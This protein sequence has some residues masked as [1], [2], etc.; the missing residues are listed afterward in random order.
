MDNKDNKKITPM[1]E[2]YLEI[3]AKYKGYVLFYRLGDFYEMFFDDALNISKALD[4]T[5]T[6]RAGTP[7]CGVPY[8]SSETYIK[9]LIDKGYKV[10]ICEQL[11]TAV[12]AKGLVE[13]EVKRIVTAGTVI[14]DSMLDDGSNNFIA[15]FFA[16]SENK[17]SGCGF[18]FADLSTGEIHLFEKRGNGMLSDVIS[19]LARYRPVEILFNQEFMSYRQVSEFVKNKLSGCTGGLLDDSAFES[20]NFEAVCEQYGL[21]NHEKLVAVDMKLAIKSLLALLRYFT[22]TQKN[23]VS[24][25]TNVKFHE[26]QEYMA[27]NLVTR[28]NL[29]LTETMRGRERRGS[30]IW[31]LDKTETSMGRRKL[32]QYIDRPL[33]SH[34]EIIKRLDVVEYF[35]K[36]ILTLGNLCD[37]LS[38]IA[39]FERLMT[40]IVYKAASPRDVYS[41]GK[42]AE[43][44]P[45]IKRLLKGNLPVLLRDISNRIFE[46][47]DVAE[48]ISK[49][50]K[51][52]PPV[53]L[54]DGGYINQGFNDELDRLRT[55]T[56]DNKFVLSRLEEEERG[57]TGIKNLKVGYNRVFGYYI[58]VSKGNI[59]NVPANYIRKQTLTNGE[60]Y[61]T[62]ELKKIEDEILSANDKIIALESE[63][64]SEITVFLTGK[65]TEIQST[66]TAVAELDVFGG[67]ANAAI[68]NDYHRPDITL[69]SVIEIKE[70]R[71]P[72]I[73]KML[74][75][76]VFT[77]NDAYIDLKDNRLIIITGPN[78]AGK[79]TYMRQV[80]VITLMAQIGSFIPAA[81]ARIGVVDQI[82]TRVGASDD[83]TAGQ[84]TFMVE[85]N[86]VAEILENA[87]SKSLVILDEIGRGTST[88]DGISIAKAVAEYINGNEIGCKTMFATHYHELIGLENTNKG[89]RNYSVAVS[90][91]GDEI[92]FLH[93]IVEGGVDDSYGVE[94]AKLAGLPK[95]VINN[96]KA[97]LKIMERSSKI[98]LEAMA[99]DREESETQIDFSSLARENT[100]NR[101]KNLDI[102]NITPIEAL[103]ELIDLKKGL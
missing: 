94:V 79:S 91:K 2:Q 55:I 18:V 90:K 97:S 72:V 101:I 63:I 99:R 69:E 30:L 103:Q 81:S 98:E 43:K 80:A 11:G 60:R 89:I 52:E 82:F 50:I 22:D 10:A 45:L 36:N 57:K 40:R 70:G 27:L 20:L 16:E 78:M 15:C 74:K 49:A 51:S 3:K 68:E 34:L 6:S 58:E 7:M 42:A 39:D 84:S 32:K 67:F 31:V 92:K 38:G 95:K 64:F 12:P 88:F 48:L 93:K 9:R 75:D 54:K 14:E 21:E 33:I 96:A 37:E 71:H 25:F 83:L 5:L 19:E 85:M 47:S 73:E 102:N 87:T 86:E 17:G 66:A 28:K 61:I 29:E 100:I 62:E 1:L 59:G 4:L 76:S 35:T 8:H 77:P 24:R 26:E 46:L 23:A 13:R 44:L 65:L 53:L 41:L 56:K